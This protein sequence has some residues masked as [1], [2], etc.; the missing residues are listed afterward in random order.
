MICP[1]FKKGIGEV[2][3]RHKTKPRYLPIF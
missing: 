3:L 1:S 2:L